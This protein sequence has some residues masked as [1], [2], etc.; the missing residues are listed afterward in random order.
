M[1]TSWAHLTH[2]NLVAATIRGYYE[3]MKGEPTGFEQ[4]VFDN[5]HRQNDQEILE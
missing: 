1:T 2:G 4:I 5:C 3:R